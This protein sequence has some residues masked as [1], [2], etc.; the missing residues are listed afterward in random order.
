[1]D[2]VVV[3]RDTPYGGAPCANAADRQRRAHPP[4]V[5]PGTISLTTYRAGQRESVPM[6]LTIGSADS[7]RRVCR[8][9]TFRLTVATGRWASVHIRPEAAHRER[10]LTGIPVS[11]ST[12]IP[13]A[14]IELCLLAAWYQSH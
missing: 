10:R 6:L 4:S 1:M 11:V 9:A 14:S 2:V 5:V 12:A 3:N 8:S 13:I 7:F